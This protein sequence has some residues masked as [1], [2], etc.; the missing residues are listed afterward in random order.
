MATADD[1]LKK[2]AKKIKKLESRKGGSYSR[3][4]KENIEAP[5]KKEKGTSFVEAQKSHKKDEDKASSMKQKPSNLGPKSTIHRGSG[6]AVGFSLSSLLSLKERLTEDRAFQY[7]LL[8]GL[9]N[10]KN[11][12][13]YSQK[14][15]CEI[16][17]MD[18]QKC[19]R[20]M[21][22]FTKIGVLELQSEFDRKTKKS[23]I[24]FFRG[25]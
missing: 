12:I 24:Y 7:L 23:R 3:P 21:T 18:E 22:Y 15:L 10:S 4:W 11:N 25:L 8:E 5:V 1:L 19:R 2:N 14:E 17:K 16:L 6:T 9:K 13:L 20:M